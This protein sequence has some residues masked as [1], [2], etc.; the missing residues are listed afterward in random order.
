MFLG[1]LLLSLAIAVVWRHNESQKTASSDRSTVQH[2]CTKV[3]CRKL[4][5]PFLGSLINFQWKFDEK[6]VDPAGA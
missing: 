3:I 2:V 5:Q 4:N 6:D 1:R